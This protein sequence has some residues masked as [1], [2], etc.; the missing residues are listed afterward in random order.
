MANISVILNVV[1]ALAD[2]VFVL[3]TLY[4]WDDNFK[5]HPI[6][7]LVT[8]IILVVVNLIQLQ[9]KFQ[10]EIRSICMVI[11]FLLNAL[12]AG[13]ELITIHKKRSIAKE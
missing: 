2:I 13:Y 12:L 5:R 3:T 7:R 10:S 4:L 1:E 8:S 9:M 6:I 11:I